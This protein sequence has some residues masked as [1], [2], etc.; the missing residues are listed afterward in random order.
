MNQIPA[1]G[2]ALRANPD[3]FGFLLA[4]VA[5]LMRRAF[6]A[7]MSAEPLCPALTPAQSRVLTWI[8]R[9]EG[10]HQRALADLLDIQPMTLA[11]LVDQLAALGLVERRADPA[12]RRAWRLHL[13][14]LARPRLH[15]I[16]RTGAATRGTALQGFAPDE[17]E[18]LI[19]LLGRVRGNLAGAA[20]GCAAQEERS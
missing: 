10:A 11:R 7:G 17:A 9:H 6:R 13:T 12:D 15:A 18:Q 14:A 2:D 16:R 19:T 1:A 3:G 20:Q 5:R 4:D 8:W